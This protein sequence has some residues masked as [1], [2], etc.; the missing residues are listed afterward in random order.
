MLT[1]HIFSKISG[2]KRLITWFCQEIHETF[3]YWQVKWKLIE[4]LSENSAFFDFRWAEKMSGALQPRARAENFIKWW[5]R[6]QARAR[7]FWMSA[8][9]PFFDE[10]ANALA[11][12]A[13]SLKEY[14]I[15]IKDI[16]TIK[17]LSNVFCYYKKQHIYVQFDHT[18]CS[19][20]TDS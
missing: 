16:F 10:R 7:F 3:Q 13:V 8:S 2:K 20:F 19:N 11:W 17:H 15:C 14:I 12:H 4:N 18:K 5:A 1:K 9:A 6:A